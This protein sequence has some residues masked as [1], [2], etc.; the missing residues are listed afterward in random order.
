[1]ITE[2]VHVD[3]KDEELRNFRTAILNILEDISELNEKLKELDKLKDEFLNM[4]SHELKNPLTP[5]ISYLDMLTKGS[6]GELSPKQKEALDIILRNTERL[7]RL[8]FDI[9]DIAKLE[10]KRMKFDMQ[11]V[12]I[13]KI[14]KN[15]IND[16]QPFA[17]EK[18]IKIMGKIGRLPTSIGDENRL[19]QVLTNL[20]NNA[21]KFSH[22][23]GK[24]SV[25][26]QKNGNKIIIGVKDNGVGIG[27]KDLPNMF[28]KF[29]QAPTNIQ[30]KSGTGL[31]LAICKGIIEA[32]RGKIWVGSKLGKGAKF[33]F[34][35]P[36]K[37]AR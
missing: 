29:Y 22:E 16:M 14:I 19:Q 26:A 30:R 4:T 20:L 5:V 12:D 31:G 8:I 34:T 23:R 36:I 32:H 7:K 25:R 9:L 21:I 6:L 13:V 10:S 35:L 37:Q 3:N 1:M 33:S 17:E 24:I 2:A 18:K 27:K 15:S 28:K 11:K